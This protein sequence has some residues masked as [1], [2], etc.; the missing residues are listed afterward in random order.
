MRV[1]VHN[2]EA[3]VHDV[4]QE[5]KFWSFLKKTFPLVHKDV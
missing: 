4:K 5:W 1:L 3:K 2:H